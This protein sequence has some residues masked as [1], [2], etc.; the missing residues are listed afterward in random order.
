[1]HARLITGCDPVVLFKHNCIITAMYYRVQ[2]ILGFFSFSFVFFFNLQRNN[3]GLFILLTSCEEK[4]AQEK[5]FK[6][7]PDQQ[8]TDNY[9]GH[10]VNLKTAKDWSV[11]EEQGLCKAGR[12]T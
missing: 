10:R 12:K 7:A 4:E 8:N 11:L 1:M 2:K 6:S 3:E 5:L 9:R